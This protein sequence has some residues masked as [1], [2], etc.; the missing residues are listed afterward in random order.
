MEAYAVGGIVFAVLGTQ[1]K[2]VVVIFFVAGGIGLLYATARRRVVT[3]RREAYHAAVGEL[4]GH[5]HESF[6]ER[7]AAYHRA[8]VVVLER[9]GKDFAGR[10][11]RLVNKHYD[12]HVL[13]RSAPVTAIVF[14]ARL[15]A[16]RVNNQPTLRQKFVGYLHGG[17]HIAAEVAAQVKDKF[18]K[19]LLAQLRERGEELGVSGFA[20]RTYADIA[21][22][23]VHHVNGI[24]GRH[25]HIAAHNLK[26]QGLCR[27][28][29]FHLDAYLRACFAFKFLNRGFIA[30]LLAHIRLAVHGND[31]VAR[32]QSHV[33]RGP[34]FDDAD[35]A[36][37][38][39][40]NIEAHADARKTALEVLHRVVHV[41]CADIDR[42]RVEL[43]KDFGQ[44]LFHQRVDVHRIDI[45]V[46]NEQKQVTDFVVGIIYDVEPPP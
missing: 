25:R 16:F 45:L 21:R 18:L 35:N 24:D 7:A 40:I 36:H 23:I 19:S 22:F 28:C 8:A 29:A 15:A 37:G 11:R 39:F 17:V 44:G 38:V 46:V 9:A 20:K 10:G 31:A 26:F 27:G 42:V 43:F 30:H 3:R 12:R 13:V 1:Q 34:A 4:Y 6:A 14:A 33:L 32:F 41:I 2:V 5:L